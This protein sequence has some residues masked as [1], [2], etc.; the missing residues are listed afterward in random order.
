MARKIAGGHTVRNAAIAGAGLATG[1]AAAF[2][3]GRHMLR[4]RAVRPT[5]DLDWDAYP[6]IEE[7]P[8]GKPVDFEDKSREGLRHHLAVLTINGN[9][10]RE[11]VAEGARPAMA[12]EGDQG[13]WRIGVFPE[14]TEFAPDPTGEPSSVIAVRIG[15]AALD[16]G[17]HLGTIGES[18]TFDS[19]ET[20]VSDVDLGR[21]IRRQYPELDVVTVPGES[22]SQQVDHIS[23]VIIGGAHSEDL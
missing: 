12:V 14:G 8:A 17:V 3:G 2:F 6:A 22:R 23:P 19:L 7:A 16:R 10:L 11:K 1:A 9:D 21:N 20:S 18:G 13:H 5:V 15:N 4:E